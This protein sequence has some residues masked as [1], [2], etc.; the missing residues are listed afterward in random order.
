MTLTPEE[1]RAELEA[2]RIL[3]KRVRRSL[4]AGSPFLILW[5]T[6]WIVGFLGSQFLP[7]ALSGPL[8]AL[9]TGLGTLASLWILF[10]RPRVGTAVRSPWPAR[11]AAVWGVLFLEIFLLILH[12]QPQ[13]GRL[14]SQLIVLPIAGMY[15]ISG[16]LSGS[17]VIALLGLF[18]MGAS[19]A[20]Y[21]WVPELYALIMALAGGGGMLL[22]GLWGRKEG[23]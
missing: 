7:E 17:R 1:V 18:L 20:V 12:V 2:I 16:V 21:L 9:A 11:M 22:L 4:Y 14:L 5:G 15:A 6:V 10:R 23:W 8:W 13:D 19:S 3:Q